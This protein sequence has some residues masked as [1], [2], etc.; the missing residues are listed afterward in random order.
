MFKTQ[1]KLICIVASKLS[2][3]VED[4]AGCPMNKAY[5][6]RSK[7][8]NLQLIQGSFTPFSFYLSSCYLESNSYP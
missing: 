3:N 1:A 7:I 6:M 5:G 2:L 4:I 8:C